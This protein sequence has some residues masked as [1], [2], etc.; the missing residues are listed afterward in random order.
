MDSDKRERFSRAIAVIGTEAFE[1]LQ[2]A[3]VAVFGLGGVGAACAEALVRGGVGTVA[4]VD[5]DKVAKSNL[6]RQ[7]IALHSTLGQAKT[8]VLRQRLLDISPEA[9]IREYPLF[10]DESTRNL[11]DLGEY[12]AVADCID[13]LEGKLLLAVHAQEQGYYLVSCMGAGNRLDPGQLAFA[14]IYETSVCPLARRMRKACRERG[15]KALRVLYSRE[16]P[17]RAVGEAAHGRHAPGSVSFV[18]PAAGFMIAG[19]IIR[20]LIAD[21]QVHGKPLQARP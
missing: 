4:L 13:T 1:R 11:V 21:P 5:H 2:K 10:Y 6:N 7:L 16:E 9:D 19:D 17:V 12:D 18:P 8:A 14:D 20:H 3:R 15:V